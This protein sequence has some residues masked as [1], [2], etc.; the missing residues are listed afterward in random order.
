MAQLPRL[1][2]SRRRLASLSI[3]LPCLGGTQYQVTQEEKEVEQESLCSRWAEYSSISAMCQ[4]RAD[5]AEP[6][7]SLK[8][9][10]TSSE[11]T[12]TVTD[13]WPY[14]E[15]VTSSCAEGSSDL[16]TLRTPSS[17][18]PRL[19]ALTSRSMR[20]LRTSPLS[21]ANL[22]RQEEGHQNAFSASS[23]LTNL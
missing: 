8:S 7:R 1:S 11:A 2:E 12:R 19:K 15:A 9:K 14:L 21:R 20:D 17:S 5:K 23:E 6:R 22:S 10:H 13:L 16:S 4:P 18:L 3:L